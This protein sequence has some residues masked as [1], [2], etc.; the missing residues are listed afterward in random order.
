MSGGD[1]VTWMDAN[2]GTWDTKEEAADAWADGE[3]RALVL[4][5]DLAAAIARAEAAE[6]D[7]A[8]WRFV[9]KNA[10]NGTIFCASLPA[11]ALN[12]DEPESEWDASVDA[13]IAAQ[14]AEGE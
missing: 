5:S 1:V 11:G 8:R 7:A 10:S 13:A 3:P 2:G 14:Q 4:Q 9:R 12:C 6:R